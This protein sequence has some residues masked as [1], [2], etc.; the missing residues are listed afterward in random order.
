MSDNLERN[1]WP[2]LYLKF[3]K[4]LDVATDVCN[5]NFYINTPE[6]FKYR[7]PLTKREN[8]F[9]AELTVPP[10]GF[11]LLT[12]ENGEV[13]FETPFAKVLLTLK[14]DCTYPVIPFVGISKKNKVIGLEETEDL[15]NFLLSNYRNNDVMTSFQEDYCV[16][17]DAI[18]LEDKFADYCLDRGCNYIFGELNYLDQVLVDRK[19]VYVNRNLKNNMM[20]RMHHMYLGEYWYTIDHATPADRY[21]RVGKFDSAFIM[22]TD[23]MEKIMI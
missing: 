10:M 8:E 18:E 17:I 15:L 9:D 14:K 3:C 7:V 21:I 20:D 2:L 1:H 11:K 5:G 22:R 19:K 6:F 13:E 23:E 12:D 16:I 4:S